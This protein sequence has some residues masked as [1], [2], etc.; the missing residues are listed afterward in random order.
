MFF[1]EKNKV[2]QNHLEHMRIDSA[3][4]AD[5]EYDIGFDIDCSFLEEKW[6][7]NRQKCIKMLPPNS[8]LSKINQVVIFFRVLHIYGLVALER[9]Y[10]MSYMRTLVISISETKLSINDKNR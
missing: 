7:Q 1:F 2:A 4:Y 3:F 9:V 6:L 8:M 5:S 10:Q